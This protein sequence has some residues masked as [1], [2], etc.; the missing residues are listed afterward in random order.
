GN[1]HTVL[2]GKIVVG[3]RV[4]GCCS[5]S[6][7]GTGRNVSG[8]ALP[9]ASVFGRTAEENHIARANL[10]GFP[11]VTFL[12]VPF[13]CLQAA[14]DIHEAAFCEVLITNLRQPVPGND[15]MP[16]GT[17]LTLAGCLIVPDVVG[18]HGESTKGNAAG[19][20]FELRITP[21]PANKNHFVNG[22]C[23][24]SSFTKSRHGLR[25]I[26]GPSR[27]FNRIRSGT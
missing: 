8:T 19:G 17:F 10:G 9:P 1:V 22:L 24:R 18:C 7:R 26:Y 4:G 5:C 27:G 11:L 25:L 21:E 6:D 16:F 13:A 23:H 15:V 20:V 14:F 3:N 2:E 12:I